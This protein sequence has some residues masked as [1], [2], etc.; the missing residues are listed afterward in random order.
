MIISASGSKNELLLSELKKRS[1][2]I[3]TAIHSE[4]RELVWTDMQAYHFYEGFFRKSVNTHYILNKKNV[5]RFLSSLDI[6]E[7]DRII[8][9]F[10][11]PRG[12]IFHAGHC[13]STAVAKS[14]SRSRSNLVLSEATPISQLFLF[15]KKHSDIHPAQQ[16]RMLRNLIL[17]LCRNR[18]ESHQRTF[19]KF[20]S[21]NIH[22]FDLLKSVFPDAPALF[23]R[24]DQES[25]LKSF[26]KRPP[27]WFKDE[28]DLEESVQGFLTKAASIPDEM[29]LKFD[30]S[31]VNAAN[32]PR[33]LAHFRV[34]P[35]PEELALMQSQFKYDSKVEFNMKTFS[36]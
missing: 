9:D 32:F 35:E 2:L 28:M 25:I 7:D 5:Y 20:T 8:G 1:G 31:E 26:R 29:L 34:L 6:L 4:T 21:H 14:L 15:F 10:I 24:R 23:L 11:R 3:P 17:A 27:A 22:F 12:F 19:I 18:V 13:G 36:S 33:M 30:Y 16:E